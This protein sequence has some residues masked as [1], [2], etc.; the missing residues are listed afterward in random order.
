MDYTPKLNF[1]RFWTFWSHFVKSV[2]YTPK[3]M[4][5]ILKLSSIILGWNF[6]FM[7]FNYI[8]K[9]LVTF[10]DVFGHFWT[11]WTHFVKLVGYRP[12]FIHDIL[13]LSSWTSGTFLKIFVTSGTFLIILLLFGRFWTCLDVSGHFWMFLDFFGR[14]WTFLTIIWSYPQSN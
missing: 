3:M 10:L 12:T 2:A 14:Y 13:K 5:D 4:Y 9:P 7:D 1:G 6:A 8:F 11:F